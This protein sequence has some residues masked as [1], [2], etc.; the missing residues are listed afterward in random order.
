MWSGQV[1]CE[2]LTWAPLVWVMSSLTS[3]RPCGSGWELEIWTRSSLRT[4]NGHKFYHSDLNIIVGKKKKN[5]ITHWPVHSTQSFRVR[6]QRFSDVSIIVP[7]C[8]C[9]QV[10]SFLVIYYQHNWL[11][12]ERKVQQPDL[13][14]LLNQRCFFI[15]GMVIRSSGLW[16][17]IFVNRPRTEADCSCHC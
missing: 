5:C 14:L 10:S 2:K 13:K 16:S 6:A 7:L 9:K 3:H 8:Y 15:S 12:Q 11:K 1:G 4:Q 17:R